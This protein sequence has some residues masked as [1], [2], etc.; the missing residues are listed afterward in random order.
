MG[1]SQGCSCK[2]HP[3]GFTLVELLV[4]IGIIALLISILLPGLQ[5][6]RRSA[7]SI[8]CSAALRQTHVAFEMYTNEYKGTMPVAVHETGNARIPIG[9]QRRWYDLV[10][11]Y[12]SKEMAAYTDIKDIRDRSVIWGCPAWSGSAAQTADPSVANDGLRPGYGMSYYTQNFFRSRDLINDYTYITTGGRGVYV[13]KNKWSKRPAEMGYL[14][15][16]QTHIVNIPGFGTNYQWTDITQ[17]QPHN[18][19]TGSP[20]GTAF[21][22]DATRHL[23]SNTPKNP[24]KRGMNMLFLDGHVQSVSVRE[25]W[26]GLT[27][28]SSR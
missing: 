11:K 1:Q 26:E 10:A 24:N 22:V 27:L 9:T 17:W 28:K 15:D 18:G 21:Y 6:A 25:A 3:R 19:L 14:I 16:S 8:K 5:Q 23:A 20:G 7:E 13:K 12:V 4:V 2:E